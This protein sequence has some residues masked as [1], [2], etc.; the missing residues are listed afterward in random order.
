MGETCPGISRADTSCLNICVAQL[1]KYV[2]RLPIDTQEP[3]AHSGRLLIDAVNWDVISQ[4]HG[5]RNPKACRQKWYDSL[6]PSMVSRGA[7][8]RMSAS[9]PWRGGLCIQQPLV[10]CN[11]SQAVQGACCIPLYMLL[12][13]GG[14]NERQRFCR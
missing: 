14:I 13:R 2:K 12:I 10:D 9:L 7:L 6:A 8:P 5:T 11:A 4:Q 1:C 3:A